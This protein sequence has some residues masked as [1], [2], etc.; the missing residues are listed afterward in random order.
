MA[1]TR[2]GAGQTALITGASYGIGIDLAA[3]FAK[4]GY[5]L[6]LSAR[7][8]APLQEVAL[9]L[10]A[11]HGVTATPIANDLGVIG[12]GRALVDAITARGLTVDVLVNNAGYGLFGAVE[13]LDDAESR[14]VMETNFF[15]TLNMIRAVLPHFRARRAGHIVN[16]SSISG[17]MGMAGVGLYCASKFAVTGLSES[18]AQELAPF[19]IRVTVVA[20]GGFRTNFAGGSM[21]LA[22]HPIGE[23]EGTPAALPRSRLARYHGTQP[24]DPAKA[25][26]AIIAAVESPN[27]PVHLLLGPDALQYVRGKVAAFSEEVTAWETLSSSTNFDT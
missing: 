24:G 3:C 25:A 21:A 4:G 15:G 2:P 10:G 13:E 20:P 5:D 23:Y 9:R 8:A 16:V 11:E 27:P 26:A 14:R 1:A 22:K 19:G 12:G 6:I 18:L 17:L 7:S